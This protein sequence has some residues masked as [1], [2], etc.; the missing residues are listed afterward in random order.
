MQSSRFPAFLAAAVCAAPALAQSSGVQQ[1]RLEL[2]ALDNNAVFRARLW[3]TEIGRPAAVFFGQPGVFVP[4]GGK[5]PVLI[6]VRDARLAQGVIGADGVYELSVFVPPSTFMA[7]Q[8]VFAQAFVPGRQG[9]LLASERVAVIAE[10][11]RT[12][13][14]ND[15]SGVLPPATQVAAGL[16]V[17]ACDFDRDGDLDLSVTTDEQTLLVVNTGGAFADETLA[18]L[19]GGFGQGSRDAEWAD[20][21]LDGDFDLLITGGVDPHGAASLPSRLLR[22]DGA[23]FFSLDPGFPAGPQYVSDAAFGDVDGDG[24]LDLVLATTAGIHGALD[25]NAL[26]INQGGAQGGTLGAFV[27]DAAFDAATWNDPLLQNEALAVGDLDR[28]GDLDLLFGRYD[29]GGVFGT[30]PGQPNVM[31]LNDGAGAFSD[32]S[33]TRLPVING[34]TGDNTN[35]LALAD[36]NGDGYLD[37]LA[38]NSHGSVPAYAAGDLLLNR[39]AAAPG[40]FDNASALLPGLTAP[41]FTIVLGATSGDV[42]LDGDTD[43]VLNSHEFF[44][45][46]GLVGS[47][48]LFVNQGLAQGGVEGTFARDTAFFDTAGFGSFICPD[49][50]FFDADGDG[51]LEYYAVAQGGILDPTK[52]QDKLARN[53]L[54]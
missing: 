10:A 52:T 36:V 24:D 19:P 22:N 17:D 23:G 37:V 33:A 2:K 47:A 48:A 21:D 8:T 42:D 29:A 31:L 40:V 35:G 51:D 27:R 30:G 26:L 41:E 1:A 38:A 39:G 14:Y 43:L 46:T 54:R 7:G 12:A 18:R 6:Q 3:S 13:R 16:D 28:D 49:G 32:A 25:T 34:G 9:M 5:P 44:G 11:L 15:V 4:A 50:A 20:V 45:S 53:A